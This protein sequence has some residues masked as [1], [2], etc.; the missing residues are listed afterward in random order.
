MKFEGG[1][2][3]EGI[4]NVLNL[5]TGIGTVQDRRTLDF[6]AA[7]A[8]KYSPEFS[9]KSGRFRGD[10]YRVFKPVPRKFRSARYRSK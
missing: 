5:E 8:W 6:I 3:E 1:G 9:D 4:V 7:T 2:E 10:L